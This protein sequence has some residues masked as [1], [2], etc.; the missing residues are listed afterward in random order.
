MA[1]PNATFTDIVTTTLRKHPKKLYDNVSK[2]NA[3]FNY[4]YK[5][6][7]VKEVTNGGYSIVEPLKYAENS[8]FQWYTGGEFLNTANNQI[9]TGAE[10]QWK[11]AAVTATITGREKRMNAGSEQIVSLYA[12]RLQDAMDTM[13]NNVNVSMFSDG[14]GSSGKEIGGL[15]LLVAD[16]GTGTVGG[17]NSSTYTW[18][19]NI[20]Q[21]AAAPLN[22]GGSV[23]VSKTTVIPLMNDLYN[24]LIRGTDKTDLLMADLNYFGFYENA[25]QD[26]QRFTSADSASSGFTT[27]KFKGNT[28]VVLENNTSA[29]PSNHMYFLDTKFLKFYVHKDANMTPLATKTSFNQD[30][31]ATTLVLQCALTCSNRS[32][33][34]VLKA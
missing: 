26:L 32:L 25:L 10:F 21:S 33:Q 17:I 12:E 16:A 20:V 13:A 30:A 34:G 14:T 18:W 15:Q 8:T 27:L 4:V 2:H 29:I 24:R 31:E 6:G 19:K 28:D 5:R 3:L 22:G 7:N 1:S 23:T 9:A 11:Q